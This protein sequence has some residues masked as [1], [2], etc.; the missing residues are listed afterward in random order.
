MIVDYDELAH[1]NNQ[2]LTDV[3]IANASKMNP[4]CL[5]MNPNPRLAPLILKL[6]EDAK[7][8]D[9]YIQ[10]VILVLLIIL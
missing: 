8:C 1:N 9:C 3:I 5:V 10:V 4:R 7:V 6:I 2:E